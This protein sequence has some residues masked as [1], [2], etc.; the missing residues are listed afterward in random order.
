[1][2]PAP[3]PAGSRQPAR[4]RLYL[5]WPAH[6]TTDAKERPLFQKLFDWLVAEAK[7]RV[8]LPT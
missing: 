3:P 7:R 5:R 1:M 4:R 8:P 2:H 6:D